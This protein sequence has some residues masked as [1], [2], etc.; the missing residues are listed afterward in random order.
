M[1]TKTLL[2]LRKT[3]GAGMN[4]CQIALEESNNDIDLAIEILR[5]K[6][7]M[8]AIKKAERGTKEGIIGLGVS[9]DR[10]IGVILLMNC[11]TDFVAQ[12][13]DF[14][15]FVN[16]L[17]NKALKTLD[18]KKEFDETQKD[19]VL[20]FGENITLGNYKILQGK[21]I[22]SYLHANKKVGVLVEFN[23]IIDKNLAH[24]IAM[25]I[26]AANPNYIKPEDVPVAIVNKEKDIYREQIN[27]EKKPEAVI[28]KIIMGKLQ[29]FY[30]EMCLYSQKFIK[31]ENVSVKNF[32]MP[33]A[34]EKDP[35]EVVT[36]IRF[37]I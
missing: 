9:E 11:E 35:I 1:D 18:V 17:V 19:M 34:Q 20:K 30:E 3:T 36:F 12:N 14:I 13:S 8:K 32:I 25:H 24:D 22:E 2:E 27:S 5:K 29:K 10:T 28:E 21:F 26:A 33:K 15:A 31:D 4:D 16:E 6:G 37:Q 7:A 23:R